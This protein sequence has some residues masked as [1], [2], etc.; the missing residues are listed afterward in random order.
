MRA[1]VTIS[2]CAGAAMLAQL[3]PSHAQKIDQGPILVIKDS[4]ALLNSSP[5]C[6]RYAVGFDDVAKELTKVTGNTLCRGHVAFS[7][8]CRRGSFWDYRQSRALPNPWQGPG[9]ASF[10][11]DKQNELIAKARTDARAIPAPAKTLLYMVTFKT[12]H[13]NAGPLS[14]SKVTAE[15]H[16]GVCRSA[17]S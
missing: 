17:H 14:H 5:G 7:A 12:L 15:A 1:F 6:P 10:T 11:V 13:V 4:S 8:P 3:A 2:L 9:T 16:Y